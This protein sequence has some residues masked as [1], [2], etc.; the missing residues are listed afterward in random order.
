VIGHR[1]NCVSAYLRKGADLVG[2]RMM[3]AREWPASGGTRPTGA[4]SP[5]RSVSVG[6][7]STSSAR[8]GVRAPC[9]FG[10]RGSANMSGTR[11]L[12]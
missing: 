1:L 8:R 6:N 11:A 10:Y 3:L 12:L 5:A 4:A 9:A 2:F 7:K